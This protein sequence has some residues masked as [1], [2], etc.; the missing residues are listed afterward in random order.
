MFSQDALDNLIQPILNRQ[1]K[2]NIYVI[3]KIVARLMDVKHLRPSDLKLLKSIVAMG[4]DIRAINAEIA[5]LADLQIRDI[6]SIIR[7]VAIDSYID[8]KPFYDYRYKSFIPFNEN[9]GLQQVVNVVGDMTAKS[10]V[11]L[12]KSKAIGFLLRDPKNPTRTKFQNLSQAYQKTIDTTIQAIQSKTMTPEDAI[13]KATKELLNSGL[14]RLYW[15]SGYNQRLDTAVRRNILDGVREINQRI[16]D[17]IGKQIN[18]DGK[19][20]SAH[21]NPAPDHEPFQG[22]IFTNEEWERLQSSKDFKDIDGEH[23]MGV[24]RIIGVWNCHH[25]AYSIIIGAKK[26][27]YTQEQLQ[28]FID[29]NHAGYTLKNGKHLTM[30]ECSQVQRRLETRIRYAKEEQ[31]LMSEIKDRPQAEQARRNVQALLSEYKMFSHA[32]GLKP[33]LHRA[34]VPG[35]NPV[36]NKFT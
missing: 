17:E 20:L 12:S 4:A 15:E 32:C 29:D 27:R 1:E 36:I 8:A 6:K 35:Y 7:M 30:Y 31:M 34:E 19:E 22:H 25:I 33:N 2:I 14:R 18:A 9:K 16:Q 26:R 28:K 3:K 5:R 24:D 10:Y 13:R 21:A 11:N 23:F